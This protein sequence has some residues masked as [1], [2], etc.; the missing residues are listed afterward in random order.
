MEP[1]WWTGIVALSQAGWYLSRVAA[2][3]LLVAVGLWSYLSHE[4]VDGLI[5]SQAAER[6]AI[7]KRGHMVVEHGQWKRCVFAPAGVVMT[8]QNAK[9]TR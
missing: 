2:V 4:A 1:K 7:T 5:E 6:A 3:I 8:C 9:T